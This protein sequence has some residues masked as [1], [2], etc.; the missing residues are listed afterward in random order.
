MNI[1]LATDEILDSNIVEKA[2]EK[3]DIQVLAQFMLSNTLEHQVISHAPDMLVIYVGEFSKQLMTQLCAIKQNGAVPVVL[4][5]PDRREASIESAVE[6]GV[7]SYIIDCDN[8]DRFKPLLDVARARFQ[9]QRQ[10]EQELDKLKQ[11]LADRK[12]ID[13]AKGILMQQKNISEEEAYSALRKLAMDKNKR[14]GEVAE[15]F[16]AAAEMLI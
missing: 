11:A 16:V 6:S 8:L 7:T 2:A 3:A 9:K 10:L 13:K 5:T 15:Q 14:M 12:V 1:L 4:F